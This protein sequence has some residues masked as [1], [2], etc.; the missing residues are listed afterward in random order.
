VIVRVWRLFHLLSQPLEPLPAGSNYPSFN[1]DNV[2][3]DGAGADD[4]SGLYIIG[5]GTTAD[6]IATHVIDVL[7]L[8]SASIPGAAG[9]PAR[10]D[11]T[12]IDD[13]ALRVLLKRSQGPRSHG[14]L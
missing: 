2:A 7:N 12:K 9:A 11:P 1:F 10:L 5:T 3:T 8:G 6:I 14:R 13:I 4:P